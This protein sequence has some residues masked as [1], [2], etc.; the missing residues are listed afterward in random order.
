MCIRDS[1]LAERLHAETLKYLA[2]IRRD[3]EHEARRA[4]D[5]WLDRLAD[6]MRNEPATRASVERFKRNLFADERLRAWAGRAWVSLR[7]SL[8]DALEDPSSDLHRALVA[9]LRDLGARLQE[10]PELRD[11]VDGHARRAAAYALSSYGP[12]LTGV[13]E[14]TV[15]RWDGEQTA[16]T[17]E[18]FV[19]K[20]LQFI[21]I[22]GSVVGALAG[23]AIHGVATLFL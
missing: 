4:V 12:A 5:D 22:N 23:L 11:R 6:E 17:L 7:D 1:L 18:L 9:A 2:G 21:R 19:G 16:R 13:I 8:L 20:D 10:D 15:A 14:E 3:R